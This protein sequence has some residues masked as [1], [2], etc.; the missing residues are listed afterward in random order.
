LPSM[1]LAAELIL[2]IYAFYIVQKKPIRLMSK[3]IS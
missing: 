3:I 1:L 2:R